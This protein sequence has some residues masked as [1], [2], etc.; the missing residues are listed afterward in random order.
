M[1]I[2]NVAESK[3]PPT[4]LQAWTMRGY[5]GR[6]APGSD[7]REPFAMF[8]LLEASGY[9]AVVAVNCEQEYFEALRPGDR[10]HHTSQIESVSAEKTTALGVGFFITELA[11]YWN[12][13]G[14]K[15]ADMRFRVFKYR[16]HKTA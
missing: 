13:R 5:R 1:P 7:E 4:M 8:E 10:I 9:P 2:F 15:V 12:Q 16:P 3:P 11:E 14:E 6:H